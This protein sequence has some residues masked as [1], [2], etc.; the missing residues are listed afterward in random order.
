M[1][2]ERRLAAGA[3]VVVVASLGGPFVRAAA[4]QEAV[5]IVRHAERA[6]R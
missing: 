4:A 5:Y 3:A 6:R 1:Q 2:N